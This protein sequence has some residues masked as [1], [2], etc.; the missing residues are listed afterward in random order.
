MCNP[1]LC[2]CGSYDPRLV[3][4]VAIK[5]LLCDLRMPSKTNSSDLA[6]DRGIGHTTRLEPWSLPT[7]NIPYKMSVNETDEVKKHVVVFLVRGLLL[8][9]IS[10][11]GPP[12][13]VSTQ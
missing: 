6:H 4:Q 8:P 10:S 3:D 7:R 1:T 2:W 11:Y 9:S 5:A 12:C 13:V